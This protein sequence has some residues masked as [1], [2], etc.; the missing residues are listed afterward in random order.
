MCHCSRVAAARKP[1]PT[2]SKSS[3]KYVSRGTLPG[4]QGYKRDFFIAA[5]AVTAAALDGAA[6]TAA[7]TTAAAEVAAAAPALTIVAPAA[8][9][10]TAAASAV[11]AA[12]AAAAE[13]IGES[14]RQS[15]SGPALEPQLQRC[16]D[17]SEGSSRKKD[18]FP[19]AAVAM[20]LL[21]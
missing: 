17:S 2:S 8:A 21:L 12:V 15:S 19:A 18:I 13:G 7:A 11:T 5:S 1:K 9:R 3:S 6:T 14:A 20:L 4:V 10:V 16:N